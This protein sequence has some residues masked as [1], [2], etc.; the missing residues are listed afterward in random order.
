MDRGFSSTVQY[1][2]VGNN[3]RYHT[4]S[5]APLKQ[6]LHTWARLGATGDARLAGPFLGMTYRRPMGKRAQRHPTHRKTSRF[7]TSPVSA[8]FGKSPILVGTALYRDREKIKLLR[9]QYF[10][11]STSPPPEKRRPINTLPQRP[12][13]ASF[14]S[15]YFL[16]IL[17]FNNNK[18]K[19]SSTTPSTGRLCQPICSPSNCRLPRILYSDFQQTHPPSFPFPGCVSL[20]STPSRLQFLQ[21]LLPPKVSTTVQPRVMARSTTNQT[22]NPYSTPPKVLPAQTADSRV[23]DCIPRLSA[24]PFLPSRTQLTIL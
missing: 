9:T 21:L 16:S 14:S 12:P 6:I 4:K 5:R 3:A 7:E 22:S 11:Q 24:C 15:F 19:N 18:T 13:K 1:C 23:L 10:T 2:T 17:S 8:G 20:Q